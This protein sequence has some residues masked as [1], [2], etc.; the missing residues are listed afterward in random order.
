MVNSKLPTASEGLA[1]EDTGMGEDAEEEEQEFEFRLFSSVSTRKTAD[2]SRSRTEGHDGSGLGGVQKLK[3]RLRSPSP[4]ARPPGDGGFVVP[5]RGWDYYFSNPELV[6][7][8]VGD[9][10]WQRGAKDK[11]TSKQLDTLRYTFRDTAVDGETILSRA[12]SV[13]WVCTFFLFGYSNL[14]PT[15]FTN[16]S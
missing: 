1:Q 10:S 7:R 12:A 2:E 16:S 8:A 9:T 4:S 13:T 6:M 3:I 14:S 15:S 11:N 5:F